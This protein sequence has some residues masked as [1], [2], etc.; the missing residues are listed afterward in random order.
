[1]FKFNRSVFSQPTKLD[2]TGFI[3]FSQK[4]T[5]FHQFFQSWPPMHASPRPIKRFAFVSFVIKRWE[6]VCVWYNLPVKHGIP[7]RSCLLAEPVDLYYN[8]VGKSKF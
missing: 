2:Q 8:S 3:R 4:L 7:I 6:P 1:M 5:G